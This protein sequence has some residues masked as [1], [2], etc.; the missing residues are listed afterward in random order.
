M[1]FHKL[2]ARNLDTKITDGCMRIEFRR[3]CFT[4]LA[5]CYQ[6]TRQSQVVLQYQNPSIYFL[7]S[8]SNVLLQL[9]SIFT[10]ENMLQ[11]KIGQLLRTLLSN[12][13]NIKILGHF[14]LLTEIWK[15]KESQKEKQKFC[16]IAQKARGQ[17]CQ[18]HIKAIITN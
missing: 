16:S 4:L 6:S 5:C 1:N 3:E 15:Q 11:K 9:L 2:H 18:V 17:R 13:F 10:F 8:L 14:L 7:S 12:I